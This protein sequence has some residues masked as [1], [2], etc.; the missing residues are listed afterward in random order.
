VEVFMRVPSLPEKNTVYQS[1]AWFSALAFGVA[2][3]ANIAL[4]VALGIGAV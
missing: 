4:L 2:A 1:V 3:V